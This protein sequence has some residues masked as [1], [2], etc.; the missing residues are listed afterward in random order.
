MS[1]YQEVQIRSRSAIIYNGYAHHTGNGVSTSAAVLAHREAI[2]LEKSRNEGRQTTTDRPAFLNSA[3]YSGQVTKGARK[4]ITK[5]VSLLIQ[6][7]PKR[8]VYN[9]VIGKNHSFQLSFIT[10]TV[11]SIDRLI[12]A[13][14]AHKLL[15]EPFLLWLRRH[16]QMKSYV[17]KAENQLRGQI[18]YHITT[19]AFVVHTALRDKWNELQLK[20]GLLDDFEKRRGHRNPNSTDIHS[21]KKIKNMESYLVKYMSKPGNRTK[22]LS[23]WI[24]K[25][26]KKASA[27]KNYTALPKNYFKHIYNARTI[28]KVWDCSKNLKEAKYFTT[29]LVFDIERIIT[30]LESRG[31][32]KVY[33]EENFSIVTFTVHDASY[34]LP[35]NS[36]KE[37]N[38]HIQKIRHGT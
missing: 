36:F 1:L 23:T 20:A 13:K 26:G 16:H 10:L 35:E 28:G 6:S 18:H 9:P 19:D 17:W 25:Y 29:A 34:I 22:A 2:Y 5:A 33:H 12:T 31:K 32:A 15:L 11:S 4:R 27:G 24:K 14:D 30:T 38:E 37:Y 21:V 3:A 8:R 7:T